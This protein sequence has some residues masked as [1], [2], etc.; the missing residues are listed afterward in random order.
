MTT[1]VFVDQIQFTY[2]AISLN[3]ENITQE[4]SLVFPHP[5]GNCMNWLLGHII[6]YRNRILTML[7][8]KTVWNEDEINCYKRGSVAK[9][10]IANLMP[11]QQLL[12]YL[13][14]TQDVLT[15]VLKEEAISDAGQ[16]KS[17]A[18]FSFHEAYHA[19]QL[20]FLRRILGKEGRIK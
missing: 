1:E 8:Q 18:L 16:I 14:Y 4:E 5:G 3:T 10:E 13:N 20:G 12:N 2:R 7:N 9:E 11:W 15:K 6:E 19:G 17:L